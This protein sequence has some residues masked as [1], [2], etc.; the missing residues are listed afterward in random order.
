MT[1]EIV[2]FSNYTVSTDGTIT[3][4][5]RNWI[6]S[7][8]VGA[9]GYKHVDLQQDGVRKKIAVHRLLALHFMPNP[10][11]RRTVNHIDGNKLNN[12]LINL[13]WATDSEN[14]QHAYDNGLNY[15]NRKVSSAEAE[16]LFLSRIMNGSTI[17]ALAKELDVGLTQLSHRM[18]EAATSLQ[19]ETAY[20]EE[21]KRQKTARQSK[22]V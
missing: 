15:Q 5:S 19:M 7:Q 20:R 18:K 9:N 17:T 6:K 1:K 13:E 8:W 16:A 4:T 14:I 11:N 2:N 12:E 21:L 22:A 3:N 10:E